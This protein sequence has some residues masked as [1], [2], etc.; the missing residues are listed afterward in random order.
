MAENSNVANATPTK[1]FF[2][3]MLTRDISLADAILD[4]VD[5]CLDGVLR[6]SEDDKIDYSQYHVKI[7]LNKD[8]F[9]IVDNCGGIPVEIAKNYAFKLGREIDDHRDSEKETIG[10]YGIGMKRALFK[11]GKDS[12]VKT[13]N[14]S[15]R[16]EVRIS[17]EWLHSKEW[18]VL[19]IKELTEDDDLMVPGTIIHVDGLYDGVSKHFDN[20]HFVSELKVAMGEHF[21]TFLEKGFKIYVNGESV[22][23]VLLEVLVSENP[24]GP[25]PFVYRKETDEV[26]VTMVIGLNSRKLIFDED[27]ENLE[28]YKLPETAG[29]TIFCNDRAVIVGDKS[30]ITGWGDNL[31]FYHAQFSIITGMVEFSSNRADK[32]PVTTTKRA[33]DTSSDIW[34]QTRTKMMEAMRVWIDYTNKWKNHPREEQKQYW[35]DSKPMSL[36]DAT[37]IVLKERKAKTLSDGSSEYNPRK[38]KVLPFPE[39]DKPSSRRIVFTRPLEEIKLVSEGLFDRD[40]EKPGIVGDQCFQRVFDELGG[41]EVK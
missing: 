32:L 8:R 3:S 1:S 10:M 29:W 38:N 17:S 40:D 12:I 27:A 4:L 9:N 7:L 30:R 2:V 5:N 15:D 19:P 6:E 18:G 26:T 36:R 41:T 28:D 39:K 35:E 25:A 23:P 31:P 33:L 21:T 37:Y 16:Y 11:M 14:G 13:M 22:E 20:D 34:L 24:E